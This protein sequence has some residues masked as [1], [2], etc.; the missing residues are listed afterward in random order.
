VTF[1]PVQAGTR[2]TVCHR[3]WA[4]IRADHPARH[5]LAGTA[6]SR[7]LGLWWGDL[8]SALREYVAEQG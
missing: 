6:F 8:M 3:G 2:V 5:G 7:M 1:E 4:A